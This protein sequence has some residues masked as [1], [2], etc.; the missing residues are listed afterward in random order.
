M[1]LKNPEGTRNLKGISTPLLTPLLLP[2]V[3]T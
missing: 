1:L 3:K 2:F